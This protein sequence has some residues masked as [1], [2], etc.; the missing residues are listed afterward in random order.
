MNIKEVHHQLNG[1]LLAK[2]YPA[3]TDEEFVTEVA[4]LEHRRIIVNENGNISTGSQNNGSV[5]E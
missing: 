5:L 4:I 3:L 1:K 2:G